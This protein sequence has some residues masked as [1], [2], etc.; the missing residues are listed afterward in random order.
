[1]KS[2]LSPLHQHSIMRLGREINP[3][4]YYDPQLPD[5][6]LKTAEVKRFS[7]LLTLLTTLDSSKLTTTTR[8]DVYGNLEG[9]EPE[10]AGI[11]YEKISTPADGRDIAVTFSGLAK[12]VNTSGL[13][14]VRNALV[15]C[16]RMSP[17]DHELPSVEQGTIR[18]A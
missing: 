16:A 18:D 12:N 10:L 14:C 2:I 11:Y 17:V 6:M 5:S 9:D 4:T 8:V 1:M 15:E 3:G 7:H 13:I